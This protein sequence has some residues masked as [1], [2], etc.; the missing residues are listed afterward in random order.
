M[1]ELQ[2]NEFETLKYFKEFAEKNNI[3]YTLYAGTLLGAVR[4][5]GFIPWDDDVDVGLLREDFEKFEELFIKSDYESQ[6]YIYMSRKLFPFNVQSFSKI[7]SKKMN[8]RE[9]M[10]NTQK[11]NFGAWIDIFPFDNIPDDPKKRYIQYK[12][13]TFYNNIIKKIMLFQVVPENKGFKR[14]IKKI[15]QKINDTIY[16]F[17]FFMHILYNRRDKYMKMYN[18]EDTTHVGDLTYYYYKD[19]KDYSRQFFKKKDLKDTTIGQF[20]TEKFNIPKNYDEILTQMYDEY[21]VLP[22]ESERKKH[23][24]EQV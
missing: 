21:M 17:Y 3:D 9:K 15:L 1:N 16:P 7:R 10:P 23:K 11:G 2:Q 20:E 5:Q 14:K 8:I 19:Y 12:K 22:P 13:I 24:I 18:N 6:G 4:H